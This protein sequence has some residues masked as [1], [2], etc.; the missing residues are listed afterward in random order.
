MLTAL[1]FNYL[2]CQPRPL[3]C[4]SFTSSALLIKAYVP[5]PYIPDN[6]AADNSL[7]TSCLFPLQCFIHT[8]PRLECLYTDPCVSANY[9]QVL[10]LKQRLPL[11][12]KFTGV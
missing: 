7:N 12:V 3:I 8:T 5:Y 1:T 4:L 6:G 11:G 9:F 10:W 2:V